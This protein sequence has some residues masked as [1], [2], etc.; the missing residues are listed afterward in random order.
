V[1]S[2]ST[3]LDMEHLEHVL[4]DS[5]FARRYELEDLLGAGGTSHVYRA[6]E[7][8]T[9]RRVAIKFLTSLLSG[10]DD[11][12]E[13]FLSE[14][15]MTGAIRHPAVVAVY[16]TGLAAGSPFMVT[17]L[18]EGRSLRQVLQK[19][20]LS[21]RMILDLAGH[22]L[23]GLDAIHS[24]GIVHRDL[25]PENI[26]V[27]GD[28]SCG[29]KIGDFGIA[30][31][32]G[33]QDAVST[34]DGTILGTPAYMSPEQVAGNPVSP[35]S[36]LYAFGLVL[37]E[38]VVGRHPYAASSA[39][40]ML[41]SQL[42]KPASVPATLCPPLKLLLEQCLAKDPQ[43]RIQ[44]AQ[45]CQHLL[46]LVEWE[47]AQTGALGQRDG[48]GA[49]AAG[50]TTL[51]MPAPRPSAVSRTELMHP[52][53]GRMAAGGLLRLLLPLALLVLT[54]PGFGNQARKGVRVKGLPAVVYAN[55]LEDIIDRVGGILGVES[56]EEHLHR[57]GRHAQ[58]RVQRRPVRQVSQVLDDLRL[59]GGLHRAV[60]GSCRRLRPLD[61]A[62][63]VVLDPRVTVPDEL[64]IDVPVGLTV[65]AK[66]I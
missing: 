27:P 59:D 57:P 61:V 49:P 41:E 8:V 20:R 44:T 1:R 39:L 18:V 66:R 64:G 34:L 62:H 51:A 60:E 63:Q 26:L 40:E 42:S 7:K 22:I 25:K 56:K 3:V 14:A 16:E 30:K 4:E 19:G 29:A 23:S 48:N 12:R 2:A 52:A 10:H 17:E 33:A 24:C 11:S 21:D 53:P 38:M 54:L 15:R 45:D 35:A 46:S 47:W 5:S 50:R 6:F 58:V 36:D 37:Y 13:R 31:Q 43:H 9:E 32:P 65:Q 28:G 55:R